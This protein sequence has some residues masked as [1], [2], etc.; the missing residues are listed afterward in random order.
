MYGGGFSEDH[1]TGLRAAGDPTLDLVS[2]FS[3]FLLAFLHA[4]D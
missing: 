4:A 2:F 3:A 1:D